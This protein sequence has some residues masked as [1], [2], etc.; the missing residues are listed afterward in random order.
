MLK[1]S[2]NTK[3]IQNTKNNQNILTTKNKQHNIKKCLSN[4]KHMSKNTRLNEM[5]ADFIILNNIFITNLNNQ[6]SIKQKN[7]ANHR[8]NE[9]R[10][11]V[12]VRKVNDVHFV[13]SLATILFTK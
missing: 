10:S 12:L 4:H 1:V 6:L 8:S 7:K 13:F 9:K 2:N 5:I 3:H 11:I